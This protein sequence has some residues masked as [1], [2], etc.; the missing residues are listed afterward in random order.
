MAKSTANSKKSVK[1]RGGSWKPGQSGNPAG[2]PKDGESWAAIIAAVGNMYPEDILEFIGRNNDLGKVIAQLPKGVQMKYLVTARV[3]AALLFEPTSGL[4][5]ELMERAEGK[6]TE[7]V[8]VTSDGEKIG[9]DDARAEILR[10]LDSIA[11]ATG[12][13][14]ISKPTDRE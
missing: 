8:D 2:R 4:W 3:Y 14:A 10:K 7:R 9:S 13:G 1:P 11:T 12:A 6:I 5:K